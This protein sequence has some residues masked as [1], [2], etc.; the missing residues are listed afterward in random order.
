MP[1][2]VNW[3]VSATCYGCEAT[4]AGVVEAHR[5]VTAG[6]IVEDLLGRGCA[7]CGGR[8]SVRIEPRDEPAQ[9][10]DL[11]ARRRAAG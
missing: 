3:R 10:V 11:D 2:L 7:V 1:T 5:D 4:A 8:V 9:V 6:D